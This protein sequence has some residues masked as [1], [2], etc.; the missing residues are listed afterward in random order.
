MTSMWKNDSGKELVV[1]PAR[2][3]VVYCLLLYAALLALTFHYRGWLVGIHANMIFVWYAAVILGAIF[4]CYVYLSYRMTTLR[5]AEGEMTRKSGI[6][7]RNF[8]R[9][10]IDKIANYGYHRPLVW[11]ILG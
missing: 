10:E 8:T 5:V 9:I 7:V 3:T 2:R 4:V 11:L 6:I 1:R